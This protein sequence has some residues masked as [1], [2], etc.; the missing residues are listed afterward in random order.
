MF[1][2]FNW[3]IVNSLAERQLLLSAGFP[4]RKIV[5]LP[6]F[7]PNS[8]AEATPAAYESRTFEHDLL[9]VGSSYRP[10]IEAVQFF[11]QECFPAVLARRPG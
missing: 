2:R 3:I 1:D 7:S 6:H 10:N 8:D 9:Y 5:W 4:A 11:L